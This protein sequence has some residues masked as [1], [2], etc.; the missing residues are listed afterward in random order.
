MTQTQE[1]SVL[2]VR[3]RRE[4]GLTRKETARIWGYTKRTVERLEN[5]QSRAVSLEKLAEYAEALG[6]EVRVEL[7]TKQGA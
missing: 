7:V 6:L 4:L 5:L 2:L 1:L 3:R